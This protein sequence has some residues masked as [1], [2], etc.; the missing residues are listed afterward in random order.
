M[1]IPSLLASL[2]AQMIKN[3]PAVQE[4]GFIPQ[5]GR[6][7]AEENGNRLQ[8]S[9]LENP[10]DREAWWATV[11]WVTK[12]RHDWVTN[13]PP[14]WTAL[15]PSP[16]SI[17]QVVR[18]HW[19]EFSVLHS[20]FP[21][22]VCFTYGNYMFQRYGAK[23]FPG[24]FSLKFFPASKSWC[25]Q[26]LPRRSSGYDLVLPLQGAQVQS[27]VRELRSQMLHCVGKTKR[28]S[29]YSLF[30]SMALY[31]WCAL[32]RHVVS[33]TCALPKECPDLQ[34]SIGNVP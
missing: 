2:M 7:P 23:D 4:T 30:Q 18:E 22:A 14:S 9:C 19:V 31:L 8:Y 1:Y 33:K 13:T 3:L 5:L 28:W 27:L 15:S 24:V 6:S 29:Q 26:G 21:L 16:H 17:L 34:N 10:M 20:N 12:S 11:H 32:A 25:S